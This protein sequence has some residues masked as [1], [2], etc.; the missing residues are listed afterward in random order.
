MSSDAL[1]RLRRYTA[2]R[3]GIV[4]AEPESRVV[5]LP[6]PVR[7][8]DMVEG[9]DLPSKD[10][11]RFRPCTCGRPVCPESAAGPTMRDKAAE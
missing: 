4:R 3:G 11:L 8:V 9:A 6:E 5:A 10:P 2:V 1:A 7:P